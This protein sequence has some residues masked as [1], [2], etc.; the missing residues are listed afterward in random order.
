MA[1][2]KYLFN[3]KGIHLRER[4]VLSW[5]NNWELQCELL[6]KGTLWDENFQFCQF[7]KF[8]LYEAI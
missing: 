1:L 6:V 3:N 5:N 8:N 7:W 2:I 4:D